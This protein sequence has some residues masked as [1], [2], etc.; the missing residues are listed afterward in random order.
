MGMRKIYLIIIYH[1]LQFN[2]LAIEGDFLGN[3]AERRV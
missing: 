3:K 2:P 1:A